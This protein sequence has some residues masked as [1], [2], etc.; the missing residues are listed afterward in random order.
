[1]KFL[2]SFLIWII[3]AEY[4]GEWQQSEWICHHQGNLD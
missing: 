1:M 4:P 3:F 2:K